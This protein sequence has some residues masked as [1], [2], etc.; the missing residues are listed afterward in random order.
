MANAFPNLEN[1]ASM[2]HKAVGINEKY[3]FFFFFFGIFFLGLHQL[4]MEI[5]R[6]GVELEL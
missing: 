3:S 4:H 5:P 2:I 6:L 1:D